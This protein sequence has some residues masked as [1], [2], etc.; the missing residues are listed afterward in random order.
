[1]L[2]ALPRQPDS[3]LVLGAS[4][5]ELTAALMMCRD[6]GTVVVVSPLGAP[7]DLN[8][9]PD[10]HRRGLTIRA[11]LPFEYEPADVEAWSQAAR[12][13]NTLMDLGLLVPWKQ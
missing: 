11:G 9:Y 10:V 3:I 13:M 12:R 8:L 5:Q 1:M 6:L 7:F 4:A 2:R